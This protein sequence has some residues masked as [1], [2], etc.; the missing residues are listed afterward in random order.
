MN[1]WQQHSRPFWRALVLLVFTSVQ[2][3]AAAPAT[4]A[5]WHFAPIGRPYFFA[6]WKA[7]APSHKHF[8]Q[9]LPVSSQTIESLT[10]H[11]DRAWWFGRG[12][13]PFGWSWGTQDAA[14]FESADAYFEYLSN[15]VDRGLPGVCFDEWVNFDE[16]NP[17]NWMLAEAC[18]RIKRANPD[19]FIAA[20][21]HMQSDALV[22]ALKRDWVDLAIIESYPHVAG[23]PAWTPK[24]ALWRLGLAKKAGV[25]EKTI[26]AFWIDPKDETFTAA[27][28]EEWIK[29]FRNEFPQ[30]PGL[31]PLFP[32]GHD[33][34]DPRTLHL[35]RV[36]DRLIEKYYIEP[37]PSVRV[38]A[39]DDGAI[40]DAGSVLVNARSDGE[41]T[42]WRLYVDGELAAQED[43]E[44]TEEVQFSPVNLAP[45]SHVLT[46]HAITRD[47]LRS[48]AQVAV[49]VR[50]SSE[51][52]KVSAPS[53][54]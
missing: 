40:L 12:V 4:P 44:E 18:R 11:T 43:T 37:A 2:A 50:E 34:I 8:K 28:L 16:K 42:A 9:V 53:S 35:T 5:P 20:F 24:L 13:R 30:M 38:V 33:T 25:M 49:A 14:P 27:W 26:P 21:T 32:G 6:W 10:D 36:C 29:R 1:I 7:P 23:E 47:W 41:A 46:V 45:G 17:K 31:A 54:D 52:E 48:V 15:Y 19:F 3:Q 51:A 39:P 22:V